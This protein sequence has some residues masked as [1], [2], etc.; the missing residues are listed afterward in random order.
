LRKKVNLG[1]SSVKRVLEK[2]DVLF[3]AMMKN[4][5]VIGIGFLAFGLLGLLVTALLTHSFCSAICTYRYEA[6][7]VRVIIQIYGIISMGLGAL[8][9]VIGAFGNALRS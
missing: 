6:H 7:L 3:S 9:V 2:G 8:F 1:C 4:A 5:L